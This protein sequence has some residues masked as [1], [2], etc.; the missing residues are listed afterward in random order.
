MKRTEELTHKCMSCRL[1]GCCLENL[2]IA[3]IGGLDRLEN[4]YRNAFEEHGAKLFFHPGHC[5][6]GGAG[7]LRTA[8]CNADIVIFITTVNSHNA[9]QIVKA[10]CKKSGKRFVVMRETG[11]ERVCRSIV[12]QFQSEPAVK[13]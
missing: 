11:P 9:L 4:H 8:A 10:V 13:R 6:G 5:A 7:R 3:L 12:E 1:Q 2:K